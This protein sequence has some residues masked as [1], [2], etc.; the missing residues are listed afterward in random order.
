MGR[1][2]A[3][4]QYDIVVFTDVSGEL[5]EHSALTAFYPHATRADF[6][7][8]WGTWRS[9]TLTELVRTHGRSS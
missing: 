1:A 7:L 5:V 4:E 9:A 6:D 2:V 3:T 8:M